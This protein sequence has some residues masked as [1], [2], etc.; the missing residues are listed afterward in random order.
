MNSRMPGLDRGLQCRVNN[1]PELGGKVTVQDPVCGM[2]VDPDAA[3]WSA[4][5]DGE[6]YSFCCEGCSKKFAGDP[7]RFLV[8]AR[9][10]PIQPS[11]GTGPYVCPMHPE[12]V[13][14]SLGP[15]P[16]CGM[17]LEPR[18][19]MIEEENPELVDMT[20]RFWFSAAL[21]RWRRATATL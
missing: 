20:R 1:E 7:E 8:D 11:A 19:A 12:I 18:T 5:H 13:E 17:A 4:A 14:A 15:C 21:S 16:I 3:R 10:E 2:S 9:A 6:T